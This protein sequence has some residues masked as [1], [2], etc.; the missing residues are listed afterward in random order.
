ML[1]RRK[2]PAWDNRGKRRKIGGL[3]GDLPSNGS[4]VYEPQSVARRPLFQAFRRVIEIFAECD[5]CDTSC[6]EIRA[7]EKRTLTVTEKN[8]GQSTLPGFL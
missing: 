3:E 7:V 1:A 6:D 4:G 5:R 2:A 8:P